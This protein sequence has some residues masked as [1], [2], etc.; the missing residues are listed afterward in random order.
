MIRPPWKRVSV[1]LPGEGSVDDEGPLDPSIVREAASFGLGLIGI[2]LGRGDTTKNA[3]DLAAFQALIDLP[4]RP[5]TNG[6]NGM[7][8]CPRFHPRSGI[9]K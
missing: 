5:N 9:A 4:V 1:L 2:E 3:T 6:F 8:S 7:P